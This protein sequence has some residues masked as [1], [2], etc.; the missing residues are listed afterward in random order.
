MIADNRLT[1]IAAWDDKL[2]GEQLREL[3]ELNLD[4]SLETTGFEM[5]EIDLLIEGTTAAPDDAADTIPSVCSGPP[6]TCHD[7]LWLLGP[8]RLLCGSALDECAYRTVMGEEQASAV[9]TDP[10]HNVPIDGHASGLGVIRHREFAM[11]AGEMDEVQFTDFLARACD[12][13]ARHSG[14]GSLHF[15]CMD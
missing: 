7:D 1:E 15:I 5:G 3:A 11:A 12:L 4:F 13:L 10:P 6:V 8:H 14:D 9:F 2:L